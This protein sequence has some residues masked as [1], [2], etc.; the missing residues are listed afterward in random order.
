M[1]LHSSPS[2]TTGFVRSLVTWVVRNIIGDVIF[3][4]VMVHSRKK[5][6]SEYWQYTAEKNEF[7]REWNK[8]VWM[9]HGFDGIITPVL[10]VPALPHG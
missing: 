3:A 4:R 6:A 2:H 1:Y 8:E 5:T 9:N 10:P 7:A